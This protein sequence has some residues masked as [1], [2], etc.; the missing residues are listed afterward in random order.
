MRRE[1]GNI[2]LKQMDSTDI[3][4]IVDSDVVYGVLFVSKLHFIEAHLPG[5]QVLFS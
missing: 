2:K 3:M 4:K 5:F 1:A